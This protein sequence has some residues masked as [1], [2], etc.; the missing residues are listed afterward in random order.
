VTEDEQQVFLSLKYSS[1]G[2]VITAFEVAVNMPGVRTVEN[3]PPLLNLWCEQGCLETLD[4]TKDNAEMVLIWK[5][6]S[7]FNAYHYWINLPPG[8]YTRLTMHEL[9]LV[10]DHVPEKK[11]E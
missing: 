5:Y 6:G 11:D 3:V 9:R 2:E 7:V 10:V 1:I 4:V 8:M